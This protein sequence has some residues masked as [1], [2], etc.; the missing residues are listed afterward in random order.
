MVSATVGTGVGFVDGEELDELDGLLLGPP[1]GLRLGAT[2]GSDVG[3]SDVDGWV[4][5]TSVQGQPVPSHMGGFKLH[6]HHL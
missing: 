6:G 3:L 2:V 5:G 4:V 1:L